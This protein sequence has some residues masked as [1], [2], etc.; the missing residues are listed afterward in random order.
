MGMASGTARTATGKIL[1][2]DDDAGIRELLL[3]ALRRHGWQTEGAA[4]GREALSWLGQQCFDVVV[5]DIQMPRMDGLTFLQ[6]LM[7]HHP[8]PV[9][10][11]SSDSRPEASIQALE[12]GGF[13]VVDH[14]ALVGA[15]TRAVTLGRGKAICLP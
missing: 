5:T 2:V 11:V 9:I 15:P 6:R 14:M 3:L 8:M 13:Q 4:D 7:E 12:L 10:V 1:V